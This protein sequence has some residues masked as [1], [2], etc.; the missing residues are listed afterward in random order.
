MAAHCCQYTAGATFSGTKNRKT[1][2]QCGPTSV[3]RRQSRET[4]CSTCHFVHK[5]IIYYIHY[6]TIVGVTAILF[7]FGSSSETKWQSNDHKVGAM[8]CSACRAMPCRAA[9]IFF[10]RRFEVAGELRPTKMPRRRSERVSRARDAGPVGCIA[11]HSATPSQ[12]RTRGR[13]S[14][15]TRSSGL[16]FYVLFLGA[17]GEVRLECAG[18]VGVQSYSRPFVRGLL[19]EQLPHPGTHWDETVQLGLILPT[20]FLFLSLFVCGI[21]VFR[22]LLTVVCSA[23]ASLGTSQPPPQPA[24]ATASLPQACVL[25]TSLRGSEFTAKDILE[26]GPNAPRRHF[27]GPSAPT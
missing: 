26:F 14:A 16:L 27:V 13:A 1:P 10:C 12:F 4:C 23:T 15:R 20:I 5:F 2:S 18:I 6:H 7:Y 17:L 8:R 22:N 9:R 19:G 25:E 11:R 24:S 21:H 3:A